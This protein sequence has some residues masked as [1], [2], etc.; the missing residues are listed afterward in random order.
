MSWKVLHILCWSPLPLAKIKLKINLENK[1]VFF[2]RLENITVFTCDHGQTYMHWPPPC[3]KRNISLLFLRSAAALP[4]SHWS[5]DHPSTLSQCWKQDTGSSY[6]FGVV[7]RAGLHR[8]F[9]SLETTTL[10]TFSLILHFYHF[11]K[12]QPMSSN[13]CIFEQFFHFQKPLTEL[14]PK[15]V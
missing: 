9:N 7:W 8:L 15:Q 14:T 4:G 1:G 13:I 10:G 6:F 3:A 2:Y 11:S 5:R 12:P